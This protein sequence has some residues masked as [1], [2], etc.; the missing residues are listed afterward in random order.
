[1]VEPTVPIIMVWDAICV[2]LIYL[3]AEW[4]P[5]AALRVGVGASWVGFTSWVAAM[6]LRTHGDHP[7]PVYRAALLLCLVVVVFMS[8]IFAL[9]IAR[10]KP[11]VL[12]PRKQQEASPV[13]GARTR[14]YKYKRRIPFPFRRSK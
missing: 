13:Y 12:P 3:T 1:M 4:H 6:V 8:V 7:S 11:I 5:R 14:I 2:G 9:I 10:D